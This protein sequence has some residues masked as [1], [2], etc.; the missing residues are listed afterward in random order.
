MTRPRRRQV[1]ECADVD[2]PDAREAETREAP[3]EKLDPATTYVLDVRHVVR[4]VLRD[5]RPEARAEHGRVAR[6]ARA[7]R[8]L[9]RHDLPQGRPGLRDPG[10]RS[11]PERIRRAGLLDGRQATLGCEVHEGHRRDGEDRGRGARDV[12]QPVLRRHRRRCRPSAGLRDRRRGD[13]RHGH[14]RANRESSGSATVR[15]PSRSSSRASPSPRADGAGRRGRPRGGRGVAVRKPEAAT[16]PPSPSSSGCA[17]AGRR[18]RRGRGR[19][20]P[21]GRRGGQDR[22]LP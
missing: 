3:T 9:R 18:D 6:R 20:R 14:G 16:A 5:A 11:D 4:L 22:A 17:V 21:P 13:G 8:L 19:L 12:G 15:P 1:T 2:A 7:G 10:R